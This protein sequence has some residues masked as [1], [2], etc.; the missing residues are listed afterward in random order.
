MGELFKRGINA[1]Q[2]NALL[3]EILPDQDAV[4]QL[5]YADYRIASEP[6]GTFRML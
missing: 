1:K 2:A 6:P 4:E 3:L 5:E